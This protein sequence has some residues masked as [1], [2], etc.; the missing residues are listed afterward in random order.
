MTPIQSRG[1]RHQSWK[2]KA[3]WGTFEDSH[4]KEVRFMFSRVIWGSILSLLCSHVTFFFSH[5]GLYQGYG[6]WKRTT[7]LYPLEH[8]HFEYCHFEFGYIV[9]NLNTVILNT[10]IL[11]FGS[12]V[13]LNTIILNTVIL[14]LVILLS[15]WGMIFLHLTLQRKAPVSV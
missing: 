6:K 10:I 14:N 12:I 13:N 8:R 2:P 11:S 1:C 9:F 15:I 5:E 7:H 4:K 3:K